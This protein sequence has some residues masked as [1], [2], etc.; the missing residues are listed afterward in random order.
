MVLVLGV[1]VSNLAWL[2]NMVLGLEFCS[3]GKFFMGELSS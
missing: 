1:E 3:C 2:T